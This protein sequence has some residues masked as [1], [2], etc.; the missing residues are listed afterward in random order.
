MKNEWHDLLSKKQ[1]GDTKDSERLLS[2][3]Q[4]KIERSSKG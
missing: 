1:R 3:Q 2:K 4:R